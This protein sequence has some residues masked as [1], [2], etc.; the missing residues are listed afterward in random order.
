MSTQFFGGLSLTEIG[1]IRLPF[2]SNVV[3]EIGFRYDYSNSVCDK[4]TY[5]LFFLT[6]KIAFFLWKGSGCDQ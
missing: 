6:V 5:K 3:E 2:S 4:E 1:F